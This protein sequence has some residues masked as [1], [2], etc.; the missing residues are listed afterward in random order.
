[1]LVLDI[2]SKDAKGKGMGSQ[3]AGSGVRWGNGRGKGGAHDCKIG[4]SDAPIVLWTEDLSTVLA[5]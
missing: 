4:V 1:M 5:F 3:W 2:A